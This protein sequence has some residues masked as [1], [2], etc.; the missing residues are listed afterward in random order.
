VRLTI[1]VRRTA[2][3]IPSAEVTYS[4]EPIVAT[5][6]EST[7]DAVDLSDSTD[8]P[9]V[10]RSEDALLTVWTAW[11]TLFATLSI[12]TERFK[13]WKH[14]K[15]ASD[16]LFEGGADG[17]FQR[18]DPEDF[19]SGPVAAL[20]L[21]VLPS[22]AQPDVIW[23]RAVEMHAGTGLLG[24]SPPGWGLSMGVGFTQV[25][26]VPDLLVPGTSRYETS[27]SS[28]TVGFLRPSDIPADIVDGRAYVRAIG[29]LAAEIRSLRASEMNVDPAER[30]VVILSDADVAA[31]DA[32]IG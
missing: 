12:T 14:R 32:E 19:V 15:A 5:K 17:N 30:S 2:V 3:L 7:V 10:M 24:T 21:A 18:L 16:A 1:E 4:K 11:E 22:G 31:M 29:A 27:E 23:L 13:A 8:Y 6:S 25:E 26:Q 20:I 28:R 9:A